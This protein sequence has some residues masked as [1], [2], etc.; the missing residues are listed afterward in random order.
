M[1]FIGLLMVAGVIG[2]T[3]G[4]E[5]G[6]YEWVD[7]GDGTEVPEG[8]ILHSENGLPLCRGTLGEEGGATGNK[9]AWRNIGVSTNSELCHTLRPGKKGRKQESFK[10]LVHAKDEHPQASHASAPE[11]ADE[12]PMVPVADV[13]LAINH[14]TG[15]IDSHRGKVLQKYMES[16]AHKPTSE[17][18]KPRRREVDYSR[19]QSREFTLDYGRQVG[20]SDRFM[21]YVETGE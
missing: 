9:P 17:G 21:R 11:I 12:A 20:V 18:F 7:G 2:V 1:R 6:E 8:A 19:E 3:N 14:L 10:Y 15:K 16:C 4:A 13:K 5:G